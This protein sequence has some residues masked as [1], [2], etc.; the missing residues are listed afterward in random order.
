M[1][2]SDFGPT[3]QDRTVEFMKLYES[4]GYHVSKFQSIKESKLNNYGK[5]YDAVIANVIAVRMPTHMATV[6]EFF[7]D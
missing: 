5:W 2:Y 1:P 3:L 4:K 6:E 7:F